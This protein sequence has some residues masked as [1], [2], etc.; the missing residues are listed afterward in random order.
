MQQVVLSFAAC[1]AICCNFRGKYLKYL[2]FWNFKILKFWILIELSGFFLRVHQIELS[3][4]RAE[5]SY[6]CMF[7]V[8]LRRRSNT[9][10]DYTATGRK[11]TNQCGP[12]HVIVLL[13]TCDT[14]ISF[15]APN[16]CN[17]PLKTHAHAHA[18]KYATHA[19]MLTRECV[20]IS[21]KR[22]PN[23]IGAI[24]KHRNK[25]PLRS[26]GVSAVRTPNGFLLPD[27][28]YI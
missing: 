26:Y 22:L 2:I 17:G 16:T 1:R 11:S 12:T 25:I 6:Y 9:V 8:R 28:V 13:T 21:Q 18:H 19:Y 24:R 14:Y 15:I 10:T 23:L 20:T 5:S 3:G 4:R 27:G 7:L